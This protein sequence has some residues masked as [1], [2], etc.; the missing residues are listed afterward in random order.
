MLVLRQY[1][2]K[3]RLASRASLRISSSTTTT[4]TRDP[5]RNS[6]TGGRHLCLLTLPECQQWRR[7]ALYRFLLPLQLGSD[8]LLPVDFV[9]FT[10][11]A[12]VI[13]M[14]VMCGEI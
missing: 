11:P 8:F 6:P 10:I 14:R 2:G 9:P 7:R 12:D 4:R 13:R 3:S 5:A 1:G